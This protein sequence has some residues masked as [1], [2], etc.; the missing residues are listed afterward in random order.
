MIV[1]ALSLAAVYPTL[2]AMIEDRVGKPHPMQHHQTLRLRTFHRD[3]AHR[4][5]ITASQIASAS[6]ASF[7]PRST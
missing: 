7:F 2:G 3:E 1:Q 4:R 6:A 5:R